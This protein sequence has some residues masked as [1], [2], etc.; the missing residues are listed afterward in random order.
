MRRLPACPRPAGALL[1]AGLSALGCAAGGPGIRA[2]PGPEAV[3]VFVF[4]AAWCPACE[5]ELPGLVRLA[6]RLAG[7][8][9]F[10]AVSLDEDGRL[11]RERLA[12]RGWRQG[13]LHDP[14]GRLL[15]ALGGQGPPFCAVVTAD[16][17]EVC[18]CDRRSRPAEAIRA[19]LERLSESSDSARP[20][21]GAQ[22]AARLRQSSQRASQRC[23][24]KSISRK[25]PRTHIRPSF[26]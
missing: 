22:A 8:A 17:A 15:G 3:R 18:A 9:R 2:E 10:V 5:R 25:R 7:R 26:S 1:A 23:S 20:S 13:W 6:E 12:R 19:C 16:G 14:E 24:S 4:L 21:R 11:V